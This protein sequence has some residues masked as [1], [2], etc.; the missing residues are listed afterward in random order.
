MDAELDR[1]W[2][3]LGYLP[4]G[5]RK[6]DLTLFERRLADM[7][8][9]YES[10]GSFK[11]AKAVK[12]S[13]YAEGWFTELYESAVAGRISKLTYNQYE[14]TWRNHLCDAFGHLYLAAIDSAAIRRFTSRKLA[15][16]LAPITVNNLMT[17][18]SAMLTDAV[19]EGLIATNAARQPSRARHG[20][21]RRASLYVEAKRATPAHFEPDEAR[22]LLA[23]T[24][25]PHR[26]MVLAALT[27][28]FRRGE[29]LGLRW[30]DIRWADRRIDLRGQLQERE[31]VGCKYNS[32]REVVLYSGLALELGPRR[33]AEGYVF[34]DDGQPWRNQGPERAFLR[35]AYDCC[36]LRRPGKMWHVLRHTYASILANHG[37]QEQVVER[38]M[39]HKRKSTTSIYTHLFRDAFDGVEEAIDSVFGVGA[40]KAA[41]EVDPSTQVEALR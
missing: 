21:S 6:A 30:E 15:D 16:G 14:G 35:D 32:E 23:A 7:R 4:E 22:A 1:Q 24:P 37:V 38:L 29:L 40:M 20:G 13:E 25:E 28:G 19:S 18:L 34:T 26:A 10:G 31:Y 12:L 11:A 3:R 33:R 27:T 5:W 36:G 39:G 17:P 2:D 8:A 41:V 9:E